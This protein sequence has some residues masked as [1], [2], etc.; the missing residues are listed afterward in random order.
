M[1]H[2]P[3]VVIVAGVPE[4]INVFGKDGVREFIVS[5]HLSCPL[6][7]AVPA[8]DFVTIHPVTGQHGGG[9]GD[10]ARQYHGSG[11]VTSAHMVPTSRFT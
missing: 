4:V 5:I 2:P 10:I 8:E 11:C 7:L 9:Q 3:D 1:L 6:E